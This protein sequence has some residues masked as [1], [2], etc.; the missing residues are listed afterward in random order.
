MN[1]EWLLYIDPRLVLRVSENINKSMHRR[2]SIFCIK[3]C[4]KAVYHRMQRISLA[5]ES[6]PLAWES[7]PIGEAACRRSRWR[8]ASTSA[9]RHLPRRHGPP[10]LTA[11][12]VDVS[13]G[14]CWR[15]QRRHA[16]AG[17][18]PGGTC[19]VSPGQGCRHSEVVF[20]GKFF[21]R[22]SLLP[23]HWCRWSLLS[24]RG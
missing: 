2:W 8:Q 18:G 20:F 10:G 21:Q 23:F 12:N 7:G 6:A 4:I 5:S 22:W 16:L 3:Q 11:A 14:T 17:T 13:T 19:H 1:D 24:K 9:C 15:W